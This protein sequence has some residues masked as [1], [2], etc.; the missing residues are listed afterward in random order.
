MTG[1]QVFK[2]V[3]QNILESIPKLVDVGFKD[4]E[5]IEENLCDQL[6]GFSPTREELIHLVSYWLKTI[7]DVDWIWFFDKVDMNREPSVYVAKYRIERI[8]EHGVFF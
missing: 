3:L 4:G 2:T 7:I 6:P 1:P 8:L 5:F